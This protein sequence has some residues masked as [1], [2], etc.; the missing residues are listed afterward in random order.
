MGAG[1]AQIEF[2]EPPA[3]DRSLGVFET[4][5]VCD[6]RAL[7]PEL[8]LARLRAS[9][10]ELYAR[11]LP[12]GLDAAIA[13]AAADSALARLRVDLGPSGEARVAVTALERAAGAPR[14]LVTVAVAGGF[15]AHKLADR[16]WLEAIEAAVGE[17]R[18]ALLVTAAGRLLETTRANV[19]L[20]RGGVLA[21]PPLDGAILPGVTRELLLERAR[22][23]GV[24]ALETPLGLA[25]LERAE[26]VALVN[27]LRRL[28]L[29]REP[30]AGAAA[31]VG[32]LRE[33]LAPAV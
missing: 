13:G 33:M 23:A 28:E 32:A 19:F 7:E 16:R 26:A 9:A 21:T 18:V 12:A 6:G 27:S 8:H 2:L 24:E 14:E 31:L 29:A 17:G 20:L 22:A 1:G 15:G 11:E 10:R 30:A 25:E 5:L 3:G 4:L